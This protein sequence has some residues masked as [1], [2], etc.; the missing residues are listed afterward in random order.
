MDRFDIKLVMSAPK[1]SVDKLS[2]SSGKTSKELKLE[3]L[4][5]V[6]FREEL[7]SRS[8]K[9][10][11]TDTA[12]RAM[13]LNFSK[14][15]TSIRSVKK[16]IALAKSIAYLEQQEIIKEE[17]ILESLSYTRPLIYEDNPNR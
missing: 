17:M 4:N 13:D 7:Y 1:V 16:A 11:M 15:N 5:A 6:K 12:K 10:K 9:I 3:V 8:I 14:H 2:T